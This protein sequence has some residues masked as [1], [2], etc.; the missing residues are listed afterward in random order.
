MYVCASPV[1]STL[2]ALVHV[3]LRSLREVGHKVT[4][5]MSDR[6]NKAKCYDFRLS[7]FNIYPAWCSLTLWDPWFGAF[8]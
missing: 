6:T 1:L 7:I 3:I 5:L 2:H 4:Q 8:H